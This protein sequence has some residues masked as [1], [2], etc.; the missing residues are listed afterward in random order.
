MSSRLSE[1]TALHESAQ[2]EA[3]QLRQRNDRLTE[4]ITELQRQ[5]SHHADDDDDG[6]YW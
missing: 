3:Y 6:Y 2:Q 4:Q 1:L 5:V